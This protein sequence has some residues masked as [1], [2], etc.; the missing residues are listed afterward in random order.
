MSSS[1][2]DLSLFEDAIQ[3]AGRKIIGR[4]PGDRYAPGFCWMFKLPMTA[5][6]RFQI[7]TI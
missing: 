1:S 6:G 3:R 7:P 4:L 5:A 2:L